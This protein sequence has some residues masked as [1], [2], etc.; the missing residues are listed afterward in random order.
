MR[1]IVQAAFSNEKL[2]VSAMRPTYLV[3]IALALLLAAADAAAGTR[4]QGCGSPGGGC[5][6]VRPLLQLAG[7]RGSDQDRARDAVRS[8]QALPLPEIMGIV[9]GRYPG[10][11][12]DA[13]LSRRGNALIY[14]I[15]LRGRGN[16]VQHLQVN[17][18]TGNILSV[19]E[20][21]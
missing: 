7:R 5:A 9:R 13:K 14:R 1:T 11:L 4:S 21:R 10:K 19:R 6:N 3:S 18:R 17:A 16:R 2:Y 20:G 15:K 8:G 12:L